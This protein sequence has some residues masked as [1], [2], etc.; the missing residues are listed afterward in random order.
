MFVEAV[1][2]ISKAKEPYFQDSSA[3]LLEPTVRQFLAVPGDPMVVNPVSPEF[4]A[5]NTD[6]RC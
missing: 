1:T 5:A 4:P 3:L 6:K 2:S